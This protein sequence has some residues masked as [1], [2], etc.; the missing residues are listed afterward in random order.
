[1]S[2]TA[3]QYDGDLAVAALVLN[4]ALTATQIGFV[5]D[6]MMTVSS[7]GW[8]LSLLYAI[9]IATGLL[10]SQFVL[11][12]L[13]SRSIPIRYA[14]CLAILTGAIIGMMSVWSMTRLAEPWTYKW[15]FGTFLGVLVPLQT[16]LLANMTT[17]T[18][19]LAGKGWFAG[20]LTE[21]LLAVVLPYKGKS[22]TVKH[23]QGA[24]HDATFIEEALAVSQDAAVAPSS[25]EATPQEETALA[26][27]TALSAYVEQTEPE[28][29]G[30]IPSPVVV[31]EVRKAEQTPILT[32][33]TT[34]AT[35]SFSGERVT[36][37]VHGEMSKRQ[38]KEL[39]SD[40]RRVSTINFDDAH[41]S[42]SQD[43]RWVRTLSGKVSFPERSGKKNRRKRENARQRHI[44]EL[45]EIL[46][47]V[48]EHYK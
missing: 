47:S 33:T 16:T 37:V 11:N 30:T 25:V 27:E 32:S 34:N 8:F 21:R 5:A 42:T 23:R 41:K 15:Y 4:I 46:K 17:E 28:T 14:W 40:L 29:P 3:K 24:L 44:E 13:W 43:G 1:M 9:V 48:V 19:A 12:R 22:E 31:P 10:H 2:T 20:S 7:Q 36:I 38:W 39:H 45:L 35:Y 18:F 26:K 6:G